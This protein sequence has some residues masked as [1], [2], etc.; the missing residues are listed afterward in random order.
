MIVTRLP[1]ARRPV[2]TRSASLLAL[3]VLF[4]LALVAPGPSAQTAAPVFRVA[5]LGADPTQVWDAFERRLR[6]LGYAEGRNLVLERRWSQGYA[7]RVPGLLADLMK[8]KPAV[9]VTDTFL[10]TDRIDPAQCV[11]LLAIGVAE[12]YGACPIFPVARRSLTASAKE[13]SA[14]H[15]QLAMAAVPSARRLLVLTNS[16]LAFLIDYVKEL[17]AAAQPGGVAVEVF[18]V[19]GGSSL[20]EVTG[21]ITRRAPDVLILGPAFDQ[22]QVRRQ[23]VGYA[24]RGRIPAIGSHVADGVVV[25]ANYDW[26]DLGRRAAGFVDQLLKGTRPADLPAT[27]PTKFEVIVDRR[28][29]RAV[30]LTLP[31]S[32]LSRAD[33]VLE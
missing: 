23:I 26:V 6:D 16:K 21:T 22:P 31:A 14:T 19:S 18:D 13:V 32:L 30:G 24:A 25:A 2:A 3:L 15:L 11:P 5:I 10:R 17:Q 7:D 1:R 29:A 20:A 12:P 33:Q 27:A 4:A 9:L 8:V 28:A